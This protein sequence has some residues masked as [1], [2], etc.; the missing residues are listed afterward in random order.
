MSILRLLLLNMA[1]RMAPPERIVTFEEQNAEEGVTVDFF[2]DED[3][4]IFIATRDTDSNGRLVY[5]FLDGTYYWTAEKTGFLSKE[6]SFV[7]DGAD[8]TVEFTMSA[9][10]LLT[11]FLEIGS[12]SSDDIVWWDLRYEVDVTVTD[13]EG[14]PLEDVTVTFHAQR[15][16]ETVED[17]TDASGEASLIL[18]PYDTVYEVTLTHDVFGVDTTWSVLV[19][20]EDETQQMDVVLPFIEGRNEVEDGLDLAHVWLQQI[21]WEDHS[22]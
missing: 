3:H 18:L 12:L 2:E 9:E 15:D 19:Y 22:E 5:A 13:A 1:G 17:I 10:P 8:E 20:D 7:V 21:E 16:Q 4:N 14:V 11:E 6:S